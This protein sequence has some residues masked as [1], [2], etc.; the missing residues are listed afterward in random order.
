MDFSFDDIFKDF[1]KDE[2]KPKEIEFF[3]PNESRKQK[4][5]CPICEKTIMLYL[6]SESVMLCSSCGYQEFQYLIKDA[7]KTT[8]DVPYT[9]PSYIC[10]RKVNHFKEILVQFQAKQ[11]TAL[12]EDLIDNVKHYALEN[13]IQIYNIESLRNVLKKLKYNKYYEHSGFILDKLGIPPPVISKELEEKLNI[14]FVQIQPSFFKHCPEN[15]IN[16]MNYH[17]ILYKFLE[18]LEK[19][20]YL[21]LIPMMKSRIKIMQQDMI[22]RKI[23]NDLKFEYVPTV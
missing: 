16:F 21:P 19:K 3:K 18:M 20:E 8:K 5:C 9:E 22:W 7:T 11:Y 13:N 17:Y 6:E 12:P 10:Y 14:L 2:I 23:C 1:E 4:D 15:K